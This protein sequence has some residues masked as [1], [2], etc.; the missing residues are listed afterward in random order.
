MT[1]W[2]GY[3]VFKSPLTFTYHIYSSCASFLCKL[4]Q[5][6]QSNDNKWI[7]H[8]EYHPDV[9]HLDVS[10]QWQRVGDSHEAKEMHSY[11][12]FQADGTA[13]SLGCQN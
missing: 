3:K 13:Y 11:Y 4:L 1:I 12:N 8:C 7:G 6:M 5:A 2:I 9:N 10:S